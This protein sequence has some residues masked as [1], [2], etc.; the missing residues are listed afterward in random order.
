MRYDLVKS[1]EIVQ[2]RNFDGT[3][4]ILAANKGEWLPRIIIDPA[5]DPATQNRTRTITI[6]ASN[7]TYEWIVTAKSQAELDAI[8]DNADIAVLQSAGKDLALVVVELVDYLL[9]NTAMTATDFTVDVRQ[10]YLDLKVI[11]DRLKS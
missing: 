6:N 10:A 2:S 4:P 5:F 7:V 9:A 8:V 3:P 11:A 1:G